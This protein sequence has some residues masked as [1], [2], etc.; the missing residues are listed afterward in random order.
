MSQL[1]EPTERDRFWLEHEAAI[2][3]SGLSAKDYAAKHGVSLHALYQAR[4]RLR[5]LGHLA[6]ASSQRRSPG[7][8]TK[9]MA[10]EQV[11]LAASPT[12]SADF[13][14][15]LPNGLALEW[16]G[17]ELPAPVIDLVERLAR[18]R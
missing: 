17:G 3:R 13:R 1:L 4:K 9:K 10:F 6:P 2:A 15:I 12:R 16:S 8:R 14:L 5:K 7:T 18:I 11:Q